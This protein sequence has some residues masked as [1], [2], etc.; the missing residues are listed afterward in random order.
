MLD[1]HKI[2]RTIFVRLVFGTGRQKEE[3]TSFFLPVKYLSFF[4]QAKI[5]RI[6]YFFVCDRIWTHAI[7]KLR[8]EW[9]AGAHEKSKKY[10][11][12]S[13]QEVQCILSPK[14]QI[15]TIRLNL[16]DSNPGILSHELLFTIGTYMMRIFFQ[17]KLRIARHPTSP[18]PPKR[19]HAQGYWKI[20]REDCF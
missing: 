9:Y 15:V 4:L 11:K 12:P 16:W 3:I 2:I 20:E 14:R 18:W 5:R 7:T 10:P 19:T 6:F 17:T 13:A 1:S 8:N